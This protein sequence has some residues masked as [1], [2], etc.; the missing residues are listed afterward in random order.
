MPATTL[1]DVLCDN[2]KSYQICARGGS[3]AYPKYA[4]PAVLVRCD[5]TDTE[6]NERGLKLANLIAS[7]LNELTEEEARALL[8]DETIPV[9]FG[10]A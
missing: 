5:R 8:A 7:R 6:D 10:R 4:T 2:A 3:I 1:F 9:N